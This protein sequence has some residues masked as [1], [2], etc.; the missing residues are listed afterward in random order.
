[1]E[2][3]K[4]TALVIEDDDMIMA[5]IVR[6]FKELGWEV[7]TAINPREA[8]PQIRG[9]QLVVS[10]YNGMEFDVTEE[11]CKNLKIP[12]IL[13]TADT[14]A[15]SSYATKILK[16]STKTRETIVNVIRTNGLYLPD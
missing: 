14:E 3:K 15:T 4:K 6:V 9:S 12:L 16:P 5:C 1:M 7:R 8:V 11:I 13:H 10:D 2:G